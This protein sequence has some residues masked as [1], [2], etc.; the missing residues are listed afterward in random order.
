MHVF[1]L[2][3]SLQLFMIAN[4]LP[5]PSTTNCDCNNKPVIVNGNFLSNWLDPRND[6][7]RISTIVMKADHVIN[8]AEERSVQVQTSGSCM[9][10][11]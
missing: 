5:L 1:I 7:S 4:S 10:V 11:Q 2:A 6:E 3:C 9:I 8:Y